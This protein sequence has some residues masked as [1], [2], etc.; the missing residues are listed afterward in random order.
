VDLDHHGIV[1]LLKVHPRDMAVKF[2]T[3]A[4]AFR[5]I[6][7][8]DSAAVVVRYAAHQAQIESLLNLLATEGLQRW[9][10]R[11]LQRYTI[12]IPQRQATQMLTQGD[13]S[14]PMPGLY[15]LV[16]TDNLYSNILGLVG[17]ADLYNPSGF[18]L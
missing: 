3:A 4:E 7:D 18:A 9:L 17:D 1:N 15:V 13:L 5:L 8:A 6:D 11:K 16:N 12:T 14:L 10:M 2:R